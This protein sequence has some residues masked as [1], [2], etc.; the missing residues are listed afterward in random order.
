[1]VCGSYLHFSPT[2][3]SSKDQERGY[4]TTDCKRNIKKKNPDCPLS[5]NSRGSVSSV[6][7]LGFISKRTDLPVLAVYVQLPSYTLQVLL[8]WDDWR[9]WEE[10]VGHDRHLQ[11]A[12]SCKEKHWLVT[13]S[14][15][16]IYIFIYIYLHIYTIS[17]THLNVYMMFV[18]PHLTTIIRNDKVTCF[19]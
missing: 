4:G 3:Y 11:T 12:W 9:G 6:V 17:H 8:L 1:M 14:F 10:L 5:S 2:Y 18:T 16:Y 19:V 7:I 13:K 15:T